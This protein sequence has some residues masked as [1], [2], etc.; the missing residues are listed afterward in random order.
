MKFLYFGDRHATF[1]QPS[2]RTDDFFETCKAK[3]LE[4]MKIARDNKVAAILQ[5]G[6]FFEEKDIK[7]E[8][9]FIQEIIDRYNLFNP[10]ELLKEFQ[11]TGK[12]D[13]R[14]LESYIPMVGIAGNHDLI[15]ESLE[16]L[17]S[18]TLGLLASMGQINLVT[19]ENPLFFTTEDGLKVAIT[20]THYHIGMDDPEN[21]EDYIVREKLGDIHIHICHGMLSDKDMGKLI[22]HTLIDNI[23][24]TKADITLCGHNHIGFGIKEID[25][26]Y[27]VNIGSVTRY[28]GDIKEIGRNVSVALIDIT[29]AGIKIEE[30]PLTSA[31][32][33]ASVIDRTHLEE[34]KKRKAV[35]KSFKD[36]IK[37]LKSSGKSLSIK[38]FIETV[39]SANAIDEPLKKDILD[40]L[41]IK[42][43]ESAKIKNEK[44]DAFITNIILENFQSHE[45]SEIDFS[46]GF[47]VLVG[48]SR[49]GKSAIERSFYWVYEN[50]P[51]GKNF[52]KRGADYAKVTITLS[53][54]TMVSRMVEAKKSGKNIYEI[55]YPDGTV[56]SGNTKILPTVQ[57]VLGFSNF[58]IDSKLSIPVNFYKQGDGWYLIG[59]N[60]SATDK[61]RVIGA[62]NGTNLADA[63]VRDLDQ[64]NN[65]IV[66]A[67]K[68]ALEKVDNINKELEGLKYLND[69]KKNIEEVNILLEKYKLLKEKVTKVKELKESYDKTLVELDKNKAIISSLSNVDTLKD[70]LF[71]VKE[72]TTLLTS[73]EKEST[74]YNNYVIELTK[75]RNLINSLGDV[76]TS[77]ENIALL[78]A[79]CNNLYFIDKHL[80]T[81]N[82]YVNNMGYNRYILQSLS[83]VDDISALLEF[84]KSK[85]EE[86]DNIIE[87][88]TLFDN[89]EKQKQDNSRIVNALKDTNDIN[90]SITKIKELEEKLEEYKNGLDTY[91]EKKKVFEKIV[92]DRIDACKNVEQK[93]QEYKQLLKDMRICPLCK[94]PLEDEQINHI[95]E[96]V[97]N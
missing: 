82:A 65:K 79:N 83:E 2:N 46:E 21:I 51:N 9:K 94:S 93:E 77:L 18:T 63:I 96:G 6:D 58:I 20:G 55:I 75:T 7:G 97:S 24:D 8:N 84:L 66:S 25:G 27:F 68:Y 36:E 19:K 29:N 13:A 64:E 59:N 3:D 57:R 17:S 14:L 91:S 61:A 48:E 92:N 45:Y 12:L 67:N 4:I 1:K 60:L 73:L 54:G 26:K 10:K 30:I 31:P 34:D 88:K 50:K 28:T 49:Q 71:D 40:R 5:P 47:N 85:K 69:L 81:Y 23:V 89:L 42:E 70:M 72:K 38:D 44:C 62:L 43:T 76:E 39:A 35:I 78:K 90:E 56:E 86:I 74:N 53:N 52:I 87:K 32:D 15:G 11:E 41:V 95:V 33:G 37:S 80:K 16:S 22:K